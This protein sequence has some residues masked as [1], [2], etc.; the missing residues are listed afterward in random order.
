MYTDTS[1][2]TLFNAVYDTMAYDFDYTRFKNKNVHI[3]SGSE[4]KVCIKTAKEIKKTC[5]YV[6]VSLFKNCDHGS[7]LTQPERL[8]KAIKKTHYNNK[9]AS[10]ASKLPLA[11]VNIANTSGSCYNRV[12]K[13][14]YKLLLIRLLKQESEKSL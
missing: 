9:S 11:F 12:I 6:R 14:Q 8:L 2:T 4:E 10:Y 7:L 3:W 5:P 13:K 1:K